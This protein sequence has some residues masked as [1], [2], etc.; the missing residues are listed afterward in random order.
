VQSTPFTEFAQILRS[1]ETR[2]RPVGVTMCII[3]EVPKWD[4]EE[5]NWQLLIII[6]KFH[7]AKVAP[8]LAVKKIR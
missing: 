1:F 5:G 6:D 7:H 2:Q 3:N 4:P 8:Y